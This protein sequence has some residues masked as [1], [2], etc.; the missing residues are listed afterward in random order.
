MLGGVSWVKGEPCNWEISGGVIG[1]A[2]RGEARA[3]VVTCLTL[4]VI[5]DDEICLA[6]INSLEMGGSGGKGKLLGFKKGI[7]H[8]WDSL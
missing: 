6:R 7:W 8:V 2:S 5:E 4:L 1:F 3:D